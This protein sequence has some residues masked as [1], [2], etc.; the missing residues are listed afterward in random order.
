MI[1]SAFAALGRFILFIAGLALVVAISL[2]V[3]GSFVLTWPI[4][5]LSPRD[6]TL[7]AT[8]N[9]ASSAMT[10][11]TVVGEKKATAAL[12]DALAMA[13]DEDVFNDHDDIERPS[14]PNFDAKIDATRKPH[15]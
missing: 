15:E 5:R 8:V 1:R 14:E 2:F 11:F 4:L 12:A 9:F 13:A 3:F 6:R 7:R 10:L